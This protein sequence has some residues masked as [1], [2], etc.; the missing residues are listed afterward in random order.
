MIVKLKKPGFKFNE[1]ELKGIPIRIEIGPKDYQKQSVMMARRDERD[2]KENLIKKSISWNN[3]NESVQ[4]LLDE[5]QK[6]LYVK[7]VKKIK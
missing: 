4:T 2:E 7:A 6:N 3:L 1:W 5:I